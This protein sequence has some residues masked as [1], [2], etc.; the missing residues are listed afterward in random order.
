MQEGQLAFPQ[1]DIRVESS[2][3]SRSAHLLG[4]GTDEDARGAA[5]QAVHRR[6]HAWRGG[7]GRAAVLLR[8]VR[9]EEGKAVHRRG[10]AWQGGTARAAVVL[11][12]LGQQEGRWP[13]PARAALACTAPAGRA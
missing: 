8:K 11:R 6:R 9:K 4:A 3:G 10:H 13:Q 5:A 1:W 7:T 2:T 12:K